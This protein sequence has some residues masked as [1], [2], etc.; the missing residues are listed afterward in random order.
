[1]WVAVSS[2][3]CFKTEIKKLCYELP[4]RE[5]AQDRREDERKSEAIMKT[6]PW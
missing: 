5:N 6:I 2:L 3:G 4:N 1:M